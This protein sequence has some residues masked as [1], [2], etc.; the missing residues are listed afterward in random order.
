MGLAG[1]EPGGERP[2]QSGVRGRL[3][4]PLFP[5]LPEKLRG[6]GWGLRKPPSVLSNIPWAFSMGPPPAWSC[7]AEGAEAA[8]PK[9]GGSPSGSMLEE[10]G[11]SSQVG[12][13][14]G[15]QENSWRCPL[16]KSLTRQS[17]PGSCEAF[18]SLGA[19][20]LPSRDLVK[21]V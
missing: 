14:A 12:L 13:P 16:R 20:G 17:H 1:R 2:R 15:P 18:K 3:F 21:K 8:N 5:H 10:L 9:R 4:S 11:P 7:S 19:A 6:S